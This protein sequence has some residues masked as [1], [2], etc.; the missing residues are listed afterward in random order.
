MLCARRNS[1]AKAEFSQTR[2]CGVHSV[3][4]DAVGVPI[5]IGTKRI[6]SIA[7]H[8]AIFPGNIFSLAADMTDSLPQK[9]LA[10]KAG[11]VAIAAGE[12]NPKEPGRRRWVPRK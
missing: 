9:P 8:A 4:A 12:R 10:A 2:F 5:A 11:Q 1:T 6:N 7:S 3:L